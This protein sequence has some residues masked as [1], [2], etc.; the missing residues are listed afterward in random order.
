MDNI[1]DPS[2]V[3]ATTKTDSSVLAFVDP[4]T[5]ISSDPETYSYSDEN[6]RSRAST[7]KGSHG[8]CRKVFVGGI[9][10]KMSD[11]IFIVIVIVIVM[12]MV[13]VIVIVMVMV[14]AISHKS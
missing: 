2:N 12:V 6:I 9:P 8:S 14:M 13:I 4:T 1:I 5:P 10:W 3:S 11:V 7:G